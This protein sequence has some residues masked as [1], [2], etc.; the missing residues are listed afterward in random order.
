[1]SQTLVQVMSRKACCLCEDAEAAVLQAEA[2][3]LCRLEVV[4]VDEKLELAAR[5]GADVPVL[6]VN[7]VA[8]MRH[9][10]DQDEL[11]EML[12]N[13]TQESVK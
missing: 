13:L 10:V 1:M 6:I 12:I 8:R 2:K 4:D 3:G 7:G 11:E 9:R 5:Y